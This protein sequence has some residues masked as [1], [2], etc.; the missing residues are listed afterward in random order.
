MDSNDSPAKAQR[1]KVIAGRKTHQTIDPEE[2]HLGSVDN[3]SAGGT[4]YIVGVKGLKFYGNNDAS[5]VDESASVAK[6]IED[7]VLDGQS[8]IDY[9]T[10][11]IGGNGGFKDLGPM[12]DIPNAYKTAA[13]G[14]QGGMGSI[15]MD[16]KS[17]Q[18]VE[19]INN[20]T[21][22]SG[23]S[24]QSKVKRDRQD[25]MRAM[26]HTRKRLNKS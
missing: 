20:M 18:S 26:E 7:S 24:G 9:D 23:E 8:R 14:F 19:D 1:G 3:M 15:E 17:A 2:S 5:H 4:R 12:R 11:S 10:G 25:I 16:G 22:R 13:N 21:G 6:P